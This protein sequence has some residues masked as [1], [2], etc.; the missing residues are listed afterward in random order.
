MLIS[1]K[2]S[3]V[4]G[5]KYFSKKIGRDIRPCLYDQKPHLV[6]SESKAVDVQ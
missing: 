1:T 6:L 4:G 5:I 2:D 3:S